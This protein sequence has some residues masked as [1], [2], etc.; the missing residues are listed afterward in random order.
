VVAEDFSRRDFLAGVLATGTLSAAVTYLAPGG[1][2]LP[3][4]QLTLMTGEDP[5][6]GRDL[7]IDMWNQ[8]NPDTNVRVMPVEG[9]TLDQRNA[10]I[11]GAL[12]GSADV[13]NLDIVHIPFFAQEQYITPIELDNVHDFLPATLKASSWEMD[14][15]SS[16]LWAAPFNTDVGMIFERL[17]S[18]ADTASATPELKHIVDTVP[19]GSSAFAGQ[20]KPSSSSS[21][22]VFVINVFEHAL[23][24]NGSILNE[25]TGLPSYELEY[26]QEALSPLYDA[27]IKGRIRMCDDEDETTEVFRSA[28]L[29]Y[30]RNWPPQYRVLLQSR[31]PEV[32]ASRIRVGPL[33]VGIL[34]GQSLALVK[35][36]KHPSR[37]EELIRFLTDSPAQKILAA[38]G[39]A[40]TRTAPYTDASLLAFIPHLEQV[41]GAV[42]QA[43]LRPIHPKYGDFTQVVADHVRKLFHDQVK[44]PSQFVYDMQGALPA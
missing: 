27:I 2:P 19:D 23:S 17:Q 30:M 44:L 4:V 35:N 10:M 3:R 7:L 42:E 37:A 28:K 25:D 9:S 41:R 29:Q 14:G 34:G 1:R 26:W 38:H 33:P 16:R 36:S 24:R 8:A 43:R 13:L 22:E 15:N 21:D 39:L 20:L 18:D 6:G 12:N 31:D 40:P 11:G 32:R 5:T